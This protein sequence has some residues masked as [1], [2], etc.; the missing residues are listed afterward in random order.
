MRFVIYDSWLFLERFS[1]ILHCIYLFKRY[2]WLILWETLLRKYCR[3]W[4]LAAI[5]Y[6]SSAYWSIFIGTTLISPDPVEFRLASLCC[7]RGRLVFPNHTFGKISFV[8]LL[9][10]GKIRLCY[11]MVIGRLAH[12][13]P[14]TF[15]L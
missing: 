1:N 6:V 11:G 12:T 15:W 2:C 10:L 9:F 5:K 7:L 4:T 8:F 13:F 3:S 14:G